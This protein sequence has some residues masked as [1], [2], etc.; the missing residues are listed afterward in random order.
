M[1]TK[2]FQ[3][4]AAEPA[5]V[6]YWPLADGGLWDPR[7]STLVEDLEDELEVFVTCVGSGRGA[8]GLGDAASAARFMGCGS[9]VIVSPDRQS[10][11]SKGFEAAA[12]SFG[13]PVVATASRWEAEAI[14][15]AYRRARHDAPK[16]A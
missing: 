16:A 8:M 2:R 4:D 12:S 14:A 6:L 7:I 3:H 11:P 13:G 5:L 1:A 15:D 10:V 9:M